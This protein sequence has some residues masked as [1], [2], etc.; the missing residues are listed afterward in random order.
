MPGLSRP[1]T[2]PPSAPLRPPAPQVS[3]GSYHAITDMIPSL[4]I[5]YPIMCYHFLAALDLRNLGDLEV[6][7]AVLKVS[8]QLLLR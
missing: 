4:A 6:P 2:P 5:R 1:L 7:V 8:S 3:W